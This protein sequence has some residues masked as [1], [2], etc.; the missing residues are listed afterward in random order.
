MLDLA[1][2][3]CKSRR[4]SRIERRLSQLRMFLEKTKTSLD[5]KRLLPPKAEQQVRFP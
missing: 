1:E 2:R 4:T 5:L 3:E